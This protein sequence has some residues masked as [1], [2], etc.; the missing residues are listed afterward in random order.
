MKDPSGTERLAPLIFVSPSQINY[1]V[2]DGTQPGLAAVAVTRNAQ[3]IASGVARVRPVAPTLFSA[4]ADGRGVAAAF[5]LHVSADGSR[6]TDL[7]FQCGAAAGSCAAVPIDLGSDTDQ[8]YLLLFGTGIRNR[9]TPATANVGG[10]PV[11][12]LAAIAQGQ[13]PGLDQVNVGPLPRSLA[14][15][16]V[17]DI[18]VTVDN[19]RANTVTATIR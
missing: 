19:A 5:A 16:G 13:F 4:N 3:T 15:K 11:P 10:L 18:V 14:G 9:T 12:V 17:V 6:S 2:P 8:V 1:V 7:I